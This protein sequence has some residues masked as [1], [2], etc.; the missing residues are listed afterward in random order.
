MNAGGVFS[1]SL[2]GSQFTT[3][4][5][6]VYAS[7]NH[8]FSHPPLGVALDE[9]QRRCVNTAFHISFHGNPRV[10]HKPTCVELT[11]GASFLIVERFV[12]GNSD[13]VYDKNK[14]MWEQIPLGQARVFARFSHSFKQIDDSATT[15]EGV[16]TAAAASAASGGGG[17]RDDESDDRDDVARREEEE[18]TFGATA[19]DVAMQ[20]CT[21][22]SNSSRAAQSLPRSP[23]VTTVVGA[24]FTGSPTPP[25]LAAATPHS[26]SEWTCV[27]KV[28]G[29][30]KMGH[31]REAT[32][33]YNTH[34]TI[35]RSAIAMEKVDGESGQLSA[36]T[37]MGVRYWVV[38]CRYQHIVTRLEVPEVDLVRY[39]T[40]TGSSASSA[41][42]SASAS[43]EVLVDDALLSASSPM[44]SPTT[45]LR[46]GS[47]NSAHIS[48]C[49]ARDEELRSTHSSSF[50]ATTTLTGGGLASEA[51]YLDL[52][53][54]M[55]RLWRRVLET[56]P[57]AETNAANED[58]AEEE[59][60]GVGHRETL[61]EALHTRIAADKCTLCFDAILTGWER[62]QAFSTLHSSSPEASCGG[63]AS[64]VSSCCSCSCTPCKAT[65]P[66]TSTV[67]ASPS[68]HTASTW[69]AKE[70]PLWFYAVTWDAALD[71]RGWCMPVLRARDFFVES[72]LPFV[73]TSE[74]VELGS[75]EYETMRQSVL[76]RCDTAGAVLYGSTK[77]VGEATNDGAE[78]AVVQVWKCRAYPHTLERVVQEY[79]VTHRLC[80]D[81]LRNK[82]KKKVSSLSRET[83]LCIKQWELHR[84]PFLVDFALWLHREKYI[85][86]STDLAAL[87]SIRGHWLSYQE[88]FK[89]VLLAQLQRQQ[90]RLSARPSSLST[91]DVSRKEERVCEECGDDTSSQAAPAEDDKVDPIMLVGP[92]GCGKSTM[93]RILYALLEEAG[94]APRWL[95]QDELGNRAAYLA[96]MRR[97]ITRGTY[98]HILLDKMHL[99]DKARADY[100]EVGVKPVLVVT[101]QHSGG[102]DAMVNAC[103]D[104][105]LQRGACHR[106]FSLSSR[107]PELRSSAAPSIEA[108]FPISTGSLPAAWISGVAAASP[109]RVPSLSPSPSLSL[110]VDGAAAAVHPLPPLPSVARLH[111]ILEASAHRYQSPAGLPCV[112]LDVTW[113][114]RH[115]V[116]LVWE[117]L[118]DKGTCELPALAQLNVEQALQSA[119][120]YERLLETYPTRVAA[121]VLRGPSSDV[122]LSQLGSCRPPTIPKTLR[123]QPQVEVVLHDFQLNPSPTALVR[124]ASQVGATRRLTVQAVVSNSKVMLLLV[125]GPSESVAAAASNATL[126]RVQTTAR[127]PT[128]GAEGDI[129]VSSGLSAPAVGGG[130]TTAMSP[131]VSQ[132][133]EDCIQSKAQQEQWAVVAKVKKVTV[134]YCETLAQRVRDD[135]EEDPYCVV[136][137]LSPPLTMDFIVSFSFP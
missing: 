57:A 111:R 10:K 54:R 22:L 136:R 23:A 45:F 48:R 29:L 121:A 104:R 25:A 113:D 131:T 2:R 32:T 63:T 67:F 75:P 64:P 100:A 50:T 85:T 7:F 84:L 132:D 79:V 124:Y 17:H 40:T 44:Q 21:H 58:E 69:K 24:A 19:A 117:A 128:A 109:T 116:E 4:T 14:K 106:T 73:P 112:E 47:T 61:V 8:S 46:N 49:A 92:Q 137:W 34:K 86:P 105:V 91:L 1:T 55:A 38:G 18:R 37:W 93:A 56:L 60:G 125:L 118:R 9:E 71:V 87:K 119:Y 39:A 11:N 134:E 83:R 62:L 31:W 98:S 82:M 6:G 129:C 126:G 28:A 26:N 108:A 27:A 133:L 5:D 65:Q 122:V 76:S 77:D 115:S 95:N 127:I 30:R 36:F 135:P 114:C 13:G 130:G 80:G 107:S 41:N 20:R 94:A 16:V 3:A 78:E 33:V 123:L 70:I 110:S 66:S 59:E 74:P 42:S 96:A 103:L 43:T 35:A 15:E 102:T 51:G 53:V 81:P 88:K 97:A 120:A 89:D 99:N 72:H 101:W 12:S 68:S 52:A 90:Q